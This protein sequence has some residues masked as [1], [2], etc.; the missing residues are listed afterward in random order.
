MIFWKDE[1][2][3]ALD[4]QS[5]STGPQRYMFAERLFISD[6]RLFKIVGLDISM[7]TKDNFNRVLLEMTKHTFPTYNFCKRERYLHRHLIKPRK[8]KRRI[9]ILV[10][11]V[12][13][14][15]ESETEQV[16]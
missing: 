6:S 7:F 10:V 5:F 14:H 2:L 13:I 4:G 1:L 3:K 16:L 8:M 15:M 11:A 12:Q 9:F